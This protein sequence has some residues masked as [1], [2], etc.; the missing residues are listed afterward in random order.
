MGIFARGARLW[1][2]YKDENGRWIN[3]RTGYAVGEEDKARR[4][5]TR[6]ES[7]ARDA[8]AAP[9]PPGTALPA[10]LTVSRYVERW[11][12]DRRGLSL[13]SWSDDANRLRK[14]VVPLIGA[15]EITA[16]QPLDVKAVILHLRKENKLAPRTIR[17]VFTTM[18]IM[19]GDAVADQLIQ[20]SPCVL[21]KGV[22]PK[23]VDKDPDWRATA[24]YD[25]AEIQTLIFDRR[26]LQDRRVLYA[27]KAL[28]GLRHSEA[29]RLRWSH[30]NQRLEP[31]AGLNL[32]KTKTGVPRSIPVHPTLD[33]LL[34]EWKEAGWERIYGRPPASDDLIV[35]TRNMTI[36]E[37]PDS[38]RALHEDL[39]AL[40]L[41]P[42]RG[43]D[44]RRT[45]ITLAQVDG[46]R[47]DILEAISHGPRGDIV[48]VYTTFP[49]PVLCE[50][51]GKLRI[52]PVGV[53][54]PPA[55]VDKT[56][57]TAVTGE[58]SSRNRWTKSATPAGF[59]PAFKP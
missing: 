48:S 53:Q 52:E 54:V 14:H 7:L 21:R 19:F 30:F 27:L 57:Y 8:R 44:L 5:L 49:W 13:A 46:A 4:Y 20:I 29:A 38:Q 41:R 24:I 9:P 26:L 35:P 43:H 33:V 37:S 32:G 12:E 10:A 17:H 47:K 1:A 2:R 34:T 42:R 23:K 15:L 36:R 16:V 28:A 31:L 58:Q 3:E 6:I 22:L 51:V 39:A 55:L 25:R 59:E 18:S 45:F 40:S 50:E 56:R 11:L